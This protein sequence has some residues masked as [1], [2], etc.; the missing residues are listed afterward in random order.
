MIDVELV[1]LVVAALNEIVAEHKQTMNDQKSVASEEVTLDL[2]LMVGT[3]VLYF[4]VLVYYTIGGN[5][6]SHSHTR[7]ILRL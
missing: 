1:G 3:T 4:I 6:H 7:S 2:A 5:S